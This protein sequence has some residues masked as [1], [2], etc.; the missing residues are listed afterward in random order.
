VL[1]GLGALLISSAQAQVIIGGHSGP[2]VSV[3]N[4]VL[5]RLGPP[6]T[7]PQLFLGGRDPGA[8]NRRVATNTAYHAP[9]RSHTPKRRV[10]TRHVTKHRTAV[11]LAAP[12][13]AAK[14]PIHTASSLN[15]IIHLIP[16]KSRLADAAP[17]TTPA[18]KTLAQATGPTAITHQETA[19]SAPTRPS[20]VALAAPTPAPAP[21][22]P[23]SSDIPTPPVVAPPQ[24][25]R[26]EAPPAPVT[27][28]SQ[29]VAAAAPPA[30]VSAAPTAPA[31]PTT[32]ASTKPPGVPSMT[33]TPAPYV[34]F[35]TVAATSPGSMTVAA[36][37][38]P[39]MTVTPTASAP[40]PAAATASPVQMAAATTA[41]NAASALKFKPGSTDLGNA[42]QPVLDAIASRLL[43]N[44][45]MRVQIVSHASG[46]SDDAMEARRVSLAR[47][48]AVRAYLID[49]GV[50]SLRIDVRA[51]GNRTDSG[52][53]ADQVE[54][55][56]V[57]Q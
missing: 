1:A 37:A 24:Q 55:Q 54:L 51:L 16:P 10:A 35:S 27:P 44:E 43:A 31:A 32:T 3:D 36:N 47:A 4:G 22:Q 21:K 17:T 34:P 29:P 7:L 8:V 12:S 18:P 9:A 40:P 5:D 26:Q 15:Q 30:P 28:P 23:A 49:K 56:I 11:A 52:P 53:A 39:P 14:A 13:R 42:P 57:S 41:G 48:V 38:P 25:A 20:V 50:R 19:V 6:L 2:A 33:V 45:T 46:G